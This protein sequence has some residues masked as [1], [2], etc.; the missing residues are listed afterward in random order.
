MTEQQNPGLLGTSLFGDIDFVYWL[1]DKGR[2]L[3]EGRSVALARTDRALEPFEV[4]TLDV[5]FRQA[6]TARE[7]WRSA[8]SFYLSFWS[9]SGIPAV[10]VG[11]WAWCS[12]GSRSRG[13][14]RRTPEGVLEVR[15]WEAFR[16]FMADFSA[17]K[18]A[19]PTLVDLWESDL[20]DATALGV[21]EEAPRES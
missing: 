11:R 8:R 16:R 7:M 19:G 4:A 6:G 21:S 15:R 12:W 17:M 18:E 2:A 10:V 14:Q 20:V 3:L 1:S 13:C 9:D 5:V